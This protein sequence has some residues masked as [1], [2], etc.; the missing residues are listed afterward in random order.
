MN[1][2][3]AA[4]IIGVIGILILILG[5]LNIYG[6][7]TEFITREFYTNFGT[8]FIGIAITVLI[9]DWLN[10]IRQEKELK[11]QLI[12]DLGSDYNPFALRAIRELRTH[13]NKKKGGWLED[14]SLKNAS[15]IGAN[16][17]NALLSGAYLYGVNLTGAV[18]RNSFLTDTCLINSILECADLSGSNFECAD[19]RGAN[20]NGTVLSKAKLFGADLRNTNVEKAITDGVEYDSKTKWPDGFEISL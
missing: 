3:I 17:T 13:G 1:S 14:G 6:A 16:L 9:I 5:Y 2:F 7:T 10:E 4:A 11:E 12:R 20:L 19:L 15:L 8:D 18:M